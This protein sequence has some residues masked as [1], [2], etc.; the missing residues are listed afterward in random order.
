[1]ASS[2]M[3]AL[4][5]SANSNILAL[6]EGHSSKPGRFILHDV[7]KEKVLQ[8]RILSIDACKVAPEDK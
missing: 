1:M 7:E 5:W 4:D 8:E 6:G 2:W 3:R